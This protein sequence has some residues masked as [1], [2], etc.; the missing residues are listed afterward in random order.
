MK[1]TIKAA[2]TTNDRKFEDRVKSFA[3]DVERAAGTTPDT[4]GRMPPAG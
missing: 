1:A 4:R 2:C 3:T